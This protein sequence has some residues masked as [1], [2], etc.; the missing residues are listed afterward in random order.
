MIAMMQAAGFQAC[1]A[2]EFF[3]SFA[4]TTKENTARKYG[5]RGANFFAGK[6]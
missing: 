4:G 6:Q 2:T 3:D 5:V 1:A